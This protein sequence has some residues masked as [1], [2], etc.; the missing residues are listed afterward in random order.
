ML[1]LDCCSCIAGSKGH[2]LSESTLSVN[3]VPRS[4]VIVLEVEREMKKERRVSYLD[5]GRVKA[6]HELANLF[7]VNSHGTTFS[8]DLVPPTMVDLDDQRLTLSRSSF[9]H[10]EY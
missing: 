2:R 7:F 10:H 5:A 6:C 8:R 4:L 9:A 3:H 1:R